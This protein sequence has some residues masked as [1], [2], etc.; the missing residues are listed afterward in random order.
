VVSGFFGIGGG[1]LIVPGLLFST[2]MPTINAVST[3]LVAIVAFGSTTAATYSLSGLVDWS[4]A[5]VFIGGGAI[6]A[7]IGCSLVHRL[8]PY[9]SM[10]NG[11][12]ASVVLIFGIAMAWSAL[13]T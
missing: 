10:L 8:K 9:Q 4:L 5:A 11:L 7:V 1:F 3:S 12:F 6:G 2:G 13:P